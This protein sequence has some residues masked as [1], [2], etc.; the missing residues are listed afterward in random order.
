MLYATEGKTG[1]KSKNVV[2]TQTLAH[3]L[4]TRVAM[5]NAYGRAPNSAT[6]ETEH[7]SDDTEYSV[8]KPANPA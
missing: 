4:A 1:V 2:I 8:T 7:R 6:D 5:T 3:A